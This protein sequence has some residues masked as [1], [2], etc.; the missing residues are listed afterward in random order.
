H[1]M[2]TGLAGGIPVPHVPFAGGSIGFDPPVPIIAEPPM[3]APPEP[4]TPEPPFPEPAVPEV[5]PP[6][7]PAPP[8]INPPEPVVV[9]PVISPPAPVIS[10]GGDWS[11]ELALP[12][13]MKKTPTTH[14]RP[15]PR[16]RTRSRPKISFMTSPSNGK[17]RDVRPCSSYL[18]VP[19]R[20]V[21]LSSLFG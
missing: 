11:P 21:A 17:N 18:S 2:T 5:V 7:V 6:V 20:P 3:P 4:P 9:W 12:H 8:I 15:A 16:M 14:Q 1:F 10:S 13:A 19:A